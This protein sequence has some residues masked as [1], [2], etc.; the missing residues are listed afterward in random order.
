MH[1]Q[2]LYVPIAV[3]ECSYSVHCTMCTAVC[4]E[5]ILLCVVLCALCNEHIVL[6]AVSCALCNEHI[7]QCSVVVCIVQGAVAVQ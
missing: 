4:N 7:L 1:L 5:H 6:S 3:C 2:R